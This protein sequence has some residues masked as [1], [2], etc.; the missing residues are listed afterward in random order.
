M[1]R[2][3]TRR[4]FLA[5]STG[6]LLLGSSYA[7]SA[8]SERLNIAFI[9]CGKRSYG[10]VGR[11][12]SQSD[13]QVVAVCD[14]EGT[15]RESAKSKVETHYAKAKKSGTYTGCRSYIDF[16]ELFE[17]ESLDAVI[18]MTPDHMHVH[19]ALAAAKKKLDIYCEKPLTQNIAEGR[20]LAN[21]VRANKV[22]FQTG[23]QQRSE[24][25]SRFRT[26][27]EMIW[28]GRIGKVKTVRVGVGG[29]PKPCDLPAQE[30]PANLDWNRWLGPAPL[31][32]YNEKLCPKGIHN[33]FPAFRHYEE[34]AGGA[35]ADI[36]AHHFDIAQWAI[37][38]DD[39]GP[40]LIEP[41]EKGEKGL[42][43]TYENG[44]VM[45]HGGPGGC[46]FE[47]T[48]GTIR[49]DRRH[50][51]SSKPEILKTP[52]EKSAR[53]VMPSNNHLRNWLECIKSR[54]DPIASVENGHRTASI[55]HLANLGYKL[56]RKLTWDPDKEVFANDA[57]ANKLRR[58]EAR[59]GWEYKT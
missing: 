25:G 23:S 37:E 29:P 32:G 52:L 42:K 34:F 54:K 51:S 55:C 7:R 26:A 19:P 11:V 15:R 9:G 33:H 22:V 57:E 31:R 2:T 43:F 21:V 10:A 39:S 38:M 53:R 44:I 20:L 16:R 48:D 45:Y 46:T 5:Q 47:G 28:N 41:P 56:R 8:P 24:F 58:R 18:I 50:L 14:V 30:T 17:K 4:Q 40:V 49:V 12:L 35:L 3:T 1:S 6:A 13:T 36:G 27:V 59:D